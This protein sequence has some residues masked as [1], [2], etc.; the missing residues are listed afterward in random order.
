[1]GKMKELQ[2]N[3]EEMELMTTLFCHA[4]LNRNPEYGV[5][6]NDP[7]YR[8]EL[9]GV[10][11]VQG[12]VINP[13]QIVNPLFK[14]MQMESVVWARS[15]QEALELAKVHVFNY[16]DGVDITNQYQG[17]KEDFVQHYVTKRYGFVRPTTD[18]S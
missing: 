4:F 6:N 16:L 18:P 8:I 10:T 1:M 17:A 12:M 7:L 3:L 14:V 2:I 11:R 9:Y 5:A 15:Y 13:D